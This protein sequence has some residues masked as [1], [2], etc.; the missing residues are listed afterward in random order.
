MTL[1]LILQ[2]EVALFR[3]GHGQYSVVRDCVPV[4]DGASTQ[5]EGSKPKA[6][7][8]ETNAVGAVEGNTVVCPATCGWFSG[9]CCGVMTKE[10]EHEGD[11]FAAL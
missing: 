4:T 6:L 10:S 8:A 1:G 3:I 7:S 5:P 11:N 9:Y 2:I